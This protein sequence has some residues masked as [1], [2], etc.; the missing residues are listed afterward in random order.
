MEAMEELVA[1]ARAVR[2]NAYCPYS[3]Y[4]VGAAIRDERGDI[5]TGCNVENI[6]YGATICAERGA[7]MKMVAAGGRTVREIAIVTK[8][9]GTPCGMCRQVLAE[10][11]PDDATLFLVDESGA[12][13]TAMLMLIFPDAFAS[14]AVKRTE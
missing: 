12:I 6:S 1:A 14:A 3:G 11:A 9:G 4:R 10:F 5:H 7:I 2:E 8:D 13:K